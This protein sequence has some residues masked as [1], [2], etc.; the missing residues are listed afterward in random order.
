MENSSNIGRTIRDFYCNGFAGREY[1]MEGSVIVAEG[2]GWIVVKKTNGLNVFMDFQNYDCNRN[3]EGKLTSGI[4]NLS[5]SE[6]MQSHIDR[7]CNTQDFK[8]EDNG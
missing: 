4:S 1:D 8:K 3:D 6:D 2:E 5:I 7:W